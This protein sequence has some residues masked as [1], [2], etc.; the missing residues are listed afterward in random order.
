MAKMKFDTV[1][2]DRAA[3]G[4]ALHATETKEVKKA[5]EFVVRG[6]PAEWPEILKAHGH[7]FAGY[8]KIAVQEKMKRDGLI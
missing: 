4:A 8:A 1:E 3:A 5:K 2:L 7:S 6:V